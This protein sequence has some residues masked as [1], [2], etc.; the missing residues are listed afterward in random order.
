MASS[1]T[2]CRHE[3]KLAYC[4]GTLPF[5][6]FSPTARTREVE[7]QH[8]GLAVELAQADRLW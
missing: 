6:P 3:T 5:A 2:F 8:D 4:H 1:T 7:R